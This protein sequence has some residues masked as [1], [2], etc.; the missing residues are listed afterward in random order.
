M[1]VFS[2]T[3]SGSAAPPIRRCGLHSAL[4]G[5]IRRRERRLGPLVRLLCALIV[6]G[7]GCRQKPI[8]V[9]TNL[10]ECICESE[11]LW[12]SPVTIVPV[13]GSGCESHILMSFCAELAT[14]LHDRRV[15]DVRIEGDCETPC[16]ADPP[17]LQRPPMLPQSGPAGVVM[18]VAI[19]DFVPYRPM[20][21][22][23]DVRIVHPADERE[24]ARVVDVFEGPQ[25]SM[26]RESPREF[27]LF[28]E[29]EREERADKEAYT[30]FL[31]NSPRRFLTGSA[32]Q[33]VDQL[34][35]AAPI[36]EPVIEPSPFPTEPPALLESE[37]MLLDEFPEDEGPI[38]ELRADR[39]ESQKV[40]L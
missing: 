11:L 10:A 23:V 14:A 37:E 12:M 5:G 35:F 9:E 7:T 1:N 28:R 16:A 18:Y 31:S 26:L 25:E 2:Q 40:G 22:A 6:L 15:P 34:R 27:R 13:C 21:M 32:Q 20:R 24:I 30:A 29:I 33:V 3:S 39:N 36:V 4:V 19:P 38:I 8:C 17:H